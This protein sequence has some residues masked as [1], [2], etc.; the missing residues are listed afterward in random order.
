MIDSLQKGDT[1]ELGWFYLSKKDEFI[2]WAEKYFDCRNIE[3]TDIYQDAVI[4]MYENIVSGKFIKE[5]AT[6]KTY[7]YGIAKNLF[8]KRLNLEQKANDQTSEIKVQWYDEQEYDSNDEAEYEATMTAFAQMKDPCKSI[9]KYF[10]Y[11]KLSMKEIAHK[12]GYKSESVVKSQKVR[13]LK[14]LKGTAKEI[15]N[16]THKLDVNYRKANRAD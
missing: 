9:L 6:I 10:Y 14:T 11:K 8:L 4:I 16:T 13:C 15:L 7:L 3:V 12:L 5:E 1:S 2:R